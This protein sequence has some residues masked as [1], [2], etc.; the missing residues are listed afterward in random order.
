MHGRSRRPEAGSSESYVGFG[1]AR[2]ISGRLS[3]R[4][5][6][7]GL[8]VSRHMRHVLGGQCVRGFE[9]FF[10]SGCGFGG[11]PA[12]WVP[13]WGIGGSSSKVHGIEV[14]I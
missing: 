10:G 4:G 7:V 3:E 6:N 2:R 13:V 12:S 9:R 14:P 11:M 1:V 8:T 5:W